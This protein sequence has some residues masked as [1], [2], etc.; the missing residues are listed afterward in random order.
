MWCV[1][2]GIVEHVLPG[3]FSA[4]MSYGLEIS[5]SEDSGPHVISPGERIKTGYKRHLGRVLLLL[6]RG[7][8]LAPE[9]DSRNCRNC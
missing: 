7:K 2:A 3:E 9:Q 5:L 1:N 4:K 8:L 6:N